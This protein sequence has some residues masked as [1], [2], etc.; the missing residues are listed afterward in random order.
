MAQPD[1][2][3]PGIDLSI[4]RID[5]DAFNHFVKRPELKKDQSLSLHFFDEFFLTYLKNNF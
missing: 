4:S 2:T 1:L 3:G 5:N